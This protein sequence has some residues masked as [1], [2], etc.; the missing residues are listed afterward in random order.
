[1]IPAVQRTGYFPADFAGQF[2]WY[3]EHAGE[4]VAFQFKSTLEATMQ[5]L[6]QQPA[7]GRARRFRDPRLKN[8]RS[9]RVAAPFRKL[10]IFYRLQGDSLDFVRLIHG[11]RDLSRRL[12]QPP[13]AD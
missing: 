5:K 2:E 11:A 7:M 10:L 3:F 1:M 8:L 9:F 6:I 13:G 4:E 12:T